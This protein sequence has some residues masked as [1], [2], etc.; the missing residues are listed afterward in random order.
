[1]DGLKKPPK[2]RSLPP[3][4]EA[5]D[6]ARPRAKAK[7][8]P[9]NKALAKK[10]AA[11]K[12]KPAKV[13]PPAPSS[14]AGGKSEGQVE[15][16]SGV[17]KPASGKKGKQAKTRAPSIW[18]F[19]RHESVGTGGSFS[20]SRK[21]MKR[22]GV[23]VRPTANTVWIRKNQESR[24]TAKV[25]AK[26][27][28]K[29]QAKTE[30]KPFRVMDLP[31]E[32]RAM[33]WRKAVVYE[34]CFVWPENERGHEQPDLAMTCRQVRQEVLPIF[35]AVNT[36]A[37]DITGTG[38][39]KSLP[40]LNKWASAL[41]GMDGKTGWFSMIRKWSFNYTPAVR[42][43]VANGKKETFFDDACVAVTFHKRQLDGLFWDAQ[44]EIHRE[45]FCIFPI[46]DKFGSCK[47][48]TVPGWLNEPVIAVTEAAKGR[49]IDDRMIVQLAMK[50][51][52]QNSRLTEFRCE[53]IYA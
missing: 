31:E 17:T 8:L 15:A 9:N 19:V 50:I 25:P 10:P 40:M 11:L 29:P 7:A 47:V 2:A 27:G 1:M 18:D 12:K 38:S 24:K 22:E 51:N 33:I 30:D 6:K 52:R 36:F 26:F 46:H 5:F 42:T 35:Y 23:L 34:H 32:L 44:I 16:G 20:A 53:E 13:K 14:R 3:P 21:K 4:G 37:V 28:T 39:F 45:A 43:E 41:Q 49:D 48:H